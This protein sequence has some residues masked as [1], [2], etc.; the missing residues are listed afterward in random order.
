M[1]KAFPWIVVALAAAWVLPSARVPSVAQ[2]QPQVHEY[3]RIPVVDGGRVKP[4]DTIARTYLRIMSNRESFKDKEGESHQAIEWLLDVETDFSDKEARSRKHPVFR[5]DHPQ[6]QNSLGLQPREGYR[7]SIEDFGSKL[8]ALAEPLQSAHRRKEENRP[9]DPF[10][11]QLFEFERHLA[12]YQR[13]ADFSIPHVVAPKTGTTWRTLQEAAPKS[14]A[15][16]TA[17][18]DVDSWRRM[19]VAYGARDA[20]QFNEAVSSYLERLKQER[21]KDVAK[22][23]LEVR[24]NFWDPFNKA[25]WLYLLG[26]VLAFLAC[27]GWSKPFNNAAWGLMAFTFVIHT[28]ALALRMHLSGRPPVTNLYSSAIFIG[29]GAALLG[30]TLERIYKIGIGNLVAA[31][32]GF[33]TLTIAHILSAD[34]DTMEVLQAVL[35]TQFWLATHVTCITLGYATTYVAGLLGL[36][37]IIE[38]VFTRRLTEERGR[39]LTRMIYGIVCFAT[40][41]SFIGTVLGGLWADDSWGRFWGWD[42]KENGAL[43]IVLWNALLLHAR[44]GGIVRARGIAVLSVFGNIVVSWSWFGVNQL[45]VGLHS[46]GFTSGVAISLVSFAFTQVLVIGAALFVPMEHWKSAPK[47]GGAPAEGGGDHA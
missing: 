35:D 28:I 46:Y 39:S 32:A 26:F 40:F 41:F 20:A 6:L 45:G 30:L 10:E 19:L 12:M 29:W 17:D 47:P 3:G 4:M 5:I 36:I 23:A 31:V 11:N 34:G 16:M 37:Y 18:P 25:K 44:W 21:P 15:A 42:P 27:L 7:Y 38:G 13:L 14:N 2:G 1:P 24:F 22:A 33:A 8:E 43:M 9:L